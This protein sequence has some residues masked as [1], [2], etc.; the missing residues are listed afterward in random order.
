MKIIWSVLG[1]MTEISSWQ[2][3]ACTIHISSTWSHM[4]TWKSQWLLSWM[5]VW[6]YSVPPNLAVMKWI[7]H[8]L[9]RLQVLIQLHPRIHICRS[10][11]TIQILKCF[12]N[13]NFAAENEY[14]TRQALY[15]VSQPFWH[16]TP[17]SR[18]WRFS[19]PKHWT[20][21]WWSFWYLA[22]LL[23]VFYDDFPFLYCKKFIF[24]FKFALAT[25]WHKGSRPPGWE[26]LP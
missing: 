10:I 2:E 5:S 15:R 14:F 19:D 24:I 16:K 18:Y 11:L 20:L 9:K 23:V 8:T 22:F 12:V 3:A 4:S 7:L 13:F 26:T 6:K 21:P 25:L 17:M 1:P